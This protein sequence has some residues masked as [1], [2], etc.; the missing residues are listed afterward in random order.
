MQFCPTSTGD[1]EATL[2]ITSNDQNENPCDLTL[3]GVGGGGDINCDELTDYDWGMLVGECSDIEYWTIIN[4]G[5]ATLNGEVL[6]AGTDAAIFEITEGG[7]VFALAP[8][9]ELTVGVRFCCDSVGPKS[10]ILRITS[11]DPDE[12][13]CDVDLSGTCP[14]FLIGGAAYTDLGN[15]LSSGEVDVEISVNGTGGTFNTTTAGMMGLWQIADV[16]PGTYAVD[17]T[18]LGCTF[19]QVVA[20]VP[21]AAPPVGITVDEVH[22][23]ENQSIQFLATCTPLE[24]DLNCEDLSSSGFGGVDVGDCSTQGT[25]TVS[26]EGTATLTGT[27]WLDGTDPEQFELTQGGGGFTLEPFQSQD[28]KVRFCP[29]SV[30]AKSAA[31]HIVSNDPDE[32]PCNLTLTGTGNGVPDVNCE[33]LAGYDY[34]SIVV[35]LCSADHSWSVKNEGTAILSGTISLSGTDPDQFV[36]TQGDGPFSLDPNEM[37]TVEI[38]FCPDSTGDKL[39]DLRIDS[40][41]PDEDP[42]SLQLD[43]QGIPPNVP[44]IN[45]EDLS[46]NGFGSKTVGFCTVEQTWNLINEGEANLTGTILLA[47][48]N[49]DEFEFTRGG[50]GFGL[51]PG[52]QRIIGVRF[53]PQ[54]SGVKVATLQID[55]N[56]ADENP[57]LIAL[58]GTGEE[59]AAIRDLAATWPSYC[60][61]EDKLV[62]IN[63]DV[64]QG[65]SA[66][67]L[68]DQLPDG[69]I[70]S[71]ISNSGF[72]DQAHNSVKW[73]IYDTFPEQVSY[74][75]LPPV[76]T[77]GVQC[78]DGEISLDG[79]PYEPVC[80]DE[81]VDG[82]DGAFIPAD[83]P[84]PYC[85]NCGDCSC[86]VCEDRQV[87]GCESSGYI[88]AWR[89]GCNDD[90]NGATRSEYIWMHGECYC[91]GWNEQAQALWWNEEACPPSASGCCV[92]KGRGL[93]RADGSANR[94]L[95]V[96]VL[97]ASWF[98]VSIDIQPPPDVSVVALNDQPPAGWEVQAISD[99]GV[100]DDVYGKVKW[101][102]F[103][104][105]GIPSQVSYELL[106]PAGTT[107][108]HCLDGAISFD[109]IG[110]SLGGDA[111]LYV[112]VLGDVDHDGDLDLADFLGVQQCFGESP[113]SGD[114]IM[115]DFDGDEDVEMDDFDAWAQAMTGPAE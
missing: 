10:A 111:C 12:P 83:S 1:K 5:D 17:A 104:D 101:G 106:P 26:N 31:L 22:E 46:S 95:P 15:P 67:S 85:E 90:M 88:C 81:C 38:R 28:V 68:E 47:G 44:E 29:L 33:D 92:A 70:A 65:T 34:Q 14:G 13:V 49:A 105:P 113:V 69:W 53:C 91:W 89:R 84:Q 48:D 74:D 8:T 55:S 27:I 97:E 42:C 24:P 4:E 16:P 98:Q 58:D 82:P 72:W 36:F 41:D 86:A 57:C 6:L 7:G 66:I 39:A 78:F 110:Q 63:L 75:A 56:D 114:C 18:K 73:S 20:G 107:G 11:D 87:E 80:G 21:G 51:G 99:G 62:E 94:V 103:H 35:G 76:G 3:E 30:G 102:M 9:E 61:G 108:Q 71:N 79:G 40:D 109:G 112:G 19:E 52:A 45:C 50:G 64:P 59:C 93:Q 43:G 37:L 23:A 96:S 115:C 25:W 2:R 100:W 32:N 77:S 60:D 54:T